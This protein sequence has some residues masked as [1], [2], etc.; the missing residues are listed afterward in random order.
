MRE[1]VL[2]YRGHTLKTTALPLCLGVSALLRRIQ[3]T[4]GV[5]D[6]IIKE[7]VS[8]ILQGTVIMYFQDFLYCGIWVRVV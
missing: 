7:A 3:E 8:V 2:L 5:K 1:G 6:P 4:Y